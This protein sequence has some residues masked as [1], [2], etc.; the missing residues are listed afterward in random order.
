MP[1][2]NQ[3]KGLPTTAAHLAHAALSYAS[4]AQLVHADADDQFIADVALPL[5]QLISFGF[6]LSLKA[7]ILHLRGT[8]QQAEACGHNLS[9]AYK[10][11]TSLGLEW[12]DDRKLE[13]CLVALDR[14]QAQFV[15]RY[16]PDT[17]EMGIPNFEKAIPLLLHFAGRVHYDVGSPLQ[18]RRKHVQPAG[19]EIS[20]DPNL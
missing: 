2:K 12:D 6:E 10:L 3:L 13:A 14:Q 15:F 1:R 4:V 9:A 17:G 7:L 11:A 20:P 8:Q 16:M 18:V 19:D 5:S